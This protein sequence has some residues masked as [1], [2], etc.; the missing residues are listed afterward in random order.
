MYKR[1][2]NPDDE[3]EELNYPISISR[4]PIEV[5]TVQ[6]VRV[7]NFDDERNLGRELLPIYTEFHAYCTSALTCGERLTLNVTTNI[8]DCTH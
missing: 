2:V 4:C 6:Q 7:I 8:S 1:V 5:N 3:R